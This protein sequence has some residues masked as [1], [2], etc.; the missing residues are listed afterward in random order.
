MTIL[1]WPHVI[2]RTPRNVALA[3]DADL[4][5]GKGHEAIAARAICNFT[6]LEPWP[7]RFR[8]SRRPVLARAAVRR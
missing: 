6:F 3:C 8:P 5:H 4:R 1:H 7:E 2:R